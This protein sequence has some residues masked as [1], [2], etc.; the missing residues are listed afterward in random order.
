YEHTATATPFLHSE[1]RWN[2]NGWN[3][4][5]PDGALFLFP[6]NY[7][8]TRNSQGAPTA[9]RDGAGHAIE[10]RRDRDRN[11]EQLTSAGG[12]FI[13]FAHDNQSR[14]TAATDD[15]GRSVRYDYDPGGRLFAVSASQRALRYGYAD[16]DLL[17]I[18]DGARRVL[19]VHQDAD[20]RVSQLDLQDGR[21]F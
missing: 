19:Q 10:F 13:R 4:R 20:R 5:F 17:T 1:F 11:L 7:S 2:G 9:M 15:R 18:D 3:L 6:E 16:I 12:P 21:S 8:G 14:V